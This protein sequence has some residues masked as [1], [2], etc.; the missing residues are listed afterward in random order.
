MLSENWGNKKSY[1]TLGYVGLGTSL[2]SYPTRKE[3]KLLIRLYSDKV[4]RDF[5]SSSTAPSL[6]FLSWVE[7]L[8][9]SESGGGRSQKINSRFASLPITS[10]QKSRWRDEKLHQHHST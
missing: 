6:V 1:L 9:I 8:G 4:F 2:A 7:V 3:G 5:L 10:S